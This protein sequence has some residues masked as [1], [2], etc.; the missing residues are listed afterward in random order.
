MDEH[1][2]YRLL[3]HYAPYNEELSAFLDRDLRAWRR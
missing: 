3:H 1:V 2:R